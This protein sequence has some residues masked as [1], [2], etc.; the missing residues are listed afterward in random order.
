MYYV[1]MILIG[2]IVGILARIITPGPN[3]PTMPAIRTGG[4]RNR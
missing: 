1:Y 3:P 4:T 2:L